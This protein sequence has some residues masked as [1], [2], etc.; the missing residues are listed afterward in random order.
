M[1]PTALDQKLYDLGFAPDAYWDSKNE[2]GTLLIDASY[3]EIELHHLIKDKT[4]IPWF[5]ADWAW[6][7]IK[8]KLKYL[9]FSKPDIGP[10]DTLRMIGLKIVLNLIDR[11]LISVDTKKV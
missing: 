3:V 10:H 11:G 1:R 8:D 6:L 4:M 7:L 5:S 9:M 2:N